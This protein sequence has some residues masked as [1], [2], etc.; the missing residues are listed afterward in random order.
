MPLARLS[1]KSATSLAQSCVSLHFKAGAWIVRTRRQASV[2]ASEPLPRAAAKARRRE[3]RV[4]LALLVLEFDEAT[5]GRL[6]AASG[7]DRRDWR[8]VVSAHVERRDLS[9]VR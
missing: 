4:L 9:G 6:A 2:E 7:A 1:I 8:M 3:Q 5:A